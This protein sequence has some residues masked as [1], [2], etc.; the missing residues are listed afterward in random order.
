MEDK[1]EW[2]T[3]KKKISNRKD[4]Q[5]ELMKDSIKRLIKHQIK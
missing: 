2:Q 4:L 1:K 5:K 3:I